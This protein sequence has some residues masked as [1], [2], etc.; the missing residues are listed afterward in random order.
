MNPG[1]LI[2]IIAYRLVV[3]ATNHTLIPENGKV[4]LNDPS[5]THSH[6]VIC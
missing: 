5:C 2:T 4:K 6:T 1:L 3:E